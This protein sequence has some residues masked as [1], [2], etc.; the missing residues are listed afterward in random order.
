MAGIKEVASL[1]GVSIATVSRVMNNKGPLSEQTK[2]TVHRAMAELNYQ[3]NDLARALGKKKQSKIIA[4]L[5]LPLQHPFYSELITY[6]EEYLYEKGYKLLLITSFM[7]IVKEENCINLIQ[8]HMIDGLIIGGHPVCEDTFLNTTIPIVTVEAILPN[9]IPYVISNNYQGG[10]IATKHLLAKGC[11]NL[12]HICG[13]MQSHHEA[14]KRAV[15][16]EDTCKAAGV[17]YSIYGTT[18]QMLKKLDYSQIVNRLLFE[19]PEVDGIFASSDIIAA[20]VIRM[21]ASIGYKVPEQLKVIGFD[22]VKMSRLMNPP[23][24]TVAQDIKM[25][26]GETV[27][28]LLDA[29]ENKKVLLETMIPVTL[30][31][32]QST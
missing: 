3:P 27:T 24:T 20:E 16:F 25:L 17:N 7:D 10:L 19:H 28:K 6:I 21:A 4:L 26:A 30:I 22:G 12:I 15:A 1:A 23:L 14:D 8:S 13:D 32:R 2:E 5:S 18:V 31:E 11:K 9:N 29:I